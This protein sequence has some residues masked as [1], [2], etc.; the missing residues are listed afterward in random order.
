MTNRI[1]VASRSLTYRRPTVRVRPDSVLQSFNVQNWAGIGDAQTP[2][3]VSPRGF[4]RRSDS[5]TLD[6]NPHGQR[7]PHLSFL[8]LTGTPPEVRGNMGSHLQFPFHLSFAFRSTLSGGALRSQW[9]S[10]RWFGNFGQF[11][12]FSY[13]CGWLPPLS[14]YR[15]GNG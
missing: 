1:L 13:L 6:E 12:R 10:C 11:F 3:V 14:A 15:V 2:Y 9:V 7:H 4:L 5:R 8:H